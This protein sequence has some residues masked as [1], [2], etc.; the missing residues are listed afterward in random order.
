M[1]DLL[2]QPHRCTSPSL[3]SKTRKEKVRLAC[4]NR[5]RASRQTTSLTDSSTS[6][7][8]VGSQEMAQDEIVIV[9]RSPFQRRSEDATLV[10]PPGLSGGGAAG[11]AP[12]RTTV[13]KAQTTY[14]WSWSVDYYYI[15]QK[16]NP[17]WIEKTSSW[18]SAAK[19]GRNAIFNIK[20]RT[21]TNYQHSL[22]SPVSWV[23]FLSQ[24][25]LA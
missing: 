1:S 13:H 17:S 25:K 2:R 19:S 5:A 4:L 16:W 7:G 6:P 12:L 20:F 10:S 18:Y 21:T 3:T 15:S 11:R 9:P 22:I 14:L 24:P 23:D 8:S